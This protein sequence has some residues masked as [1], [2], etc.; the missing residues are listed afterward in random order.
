MS[1]SLEKDLHS[2]YIDGEM[3]EG[4]LSQYESLVSSNEK[5]KAILEKMQALH[6]VLKEDSRQKTVS[7]DF[8]EES[9][10]RLQTKMRYAKN[11][12]LSSQPKSFVSPF[13]KYAS[14]FAAAAAVFALVFIPVHY[15]SL[16]QAKETAVAAISIMK[17]NSIEPIAKKDV[18]V[19]GNIKKEDLSKG[20][21][22]NPTS[23]QAVAKNSSSSSSVETVDSFIE[24]KLP[25]E[26]KTIYATNLA[27]SYGSRTLFGSNTNTIERR[28]R[29]QLTAV[30]PFIPD[31]SSSSITI[32]VPNFSEIGNNIELMKIQDEPGK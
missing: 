16:S 22:V 28:F 8:M 14:S 21:A 9:F 27:S 11:V 5:E 1:T 13:V 7:Q 15:N 17:Q 12:S 26:Q 10:E 32:S 23:S 6:S 20:L 19:D 24:E 31:F 2:V 3:P 18:V 29:E 25:V 30:D 4:F